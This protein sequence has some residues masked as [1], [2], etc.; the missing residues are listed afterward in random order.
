LPVCQRLSTTADLRCNLCYR[1]VFAFGAHGVA[2]VAPR[3]ALNWRATLNR[4]TWVDE[5]WLERTVSALN[6]TLQAELPLEVQAT[7]KAREA[8][9]RQLLAQ[10]HSAENDVDNIDKGRD[11]ERRGR[12]TGSLEWRQARGELGSSP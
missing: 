4:R 12:Q 10:L 6:A 8:L 5:T 2:D 11:D 3:Y 9:E 1:Y 7:V